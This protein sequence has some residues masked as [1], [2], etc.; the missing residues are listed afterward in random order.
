[1]VN[2]ALKNTGNHQ[3]SDL[4]RNRMTLSANYKLL[5]PKPKPTRNPRILVSDAYLPEQPVL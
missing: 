1:M 4:E 3:R 2:Q 5:L